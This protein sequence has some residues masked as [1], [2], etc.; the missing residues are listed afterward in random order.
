MILVSF[1]CIATFLGVSALLLWQWHPL[2]WLL[3]S[4]PLVCRKHRHRHDRILC[5]QA[6]KCLHFLHKEAKLLNKSP[7]NAENIL[8]RL[9]SLL[10]PSSTF[11][12]QREHLHCLAQHIRKG[13]QIC[14]EKN[15][16]LLHNTSCRQKITSNMATDLNQLISINAHLERLDL[17]AAEQEMR[18]EYLIQLARNYAAAHHSTKLLACI[19]AAKKIQRF[20][21]KLLK[22]IHRTEKQLLIIDRR[23]TMHTITAGKDE[24]NWLSLFDKPIRQYSTR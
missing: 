11:K 23:I 15:Q 4:H 18:T 9:Q 13:H 8:Q 12:K 16:P 14:W 7:E 5:R 6:K 17:A 1:I 2:H 19:N 10:L 21:R 22:S 20:K 24:R 3:H